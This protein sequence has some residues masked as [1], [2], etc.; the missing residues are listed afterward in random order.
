MNVIEA[1]HGRR[2][3]RTYRDEP[4]ERSLIEELVWAAV[5]APTPPASGDMPWAV[6]VIEGRDRLATL[7]ARAKSH[8]RET[9]PEPHARPWAERPD[10]QVFWG[11]PVAV[12]ICSRAGNPETPF[13]CCRAGQNLT[14]LAHARGLGSCWIGS[15]LPWLQ[16]DEGRLATGLPAGFDASSVVALGYAEQVLPGQSAPRPAITWCEAP[17]LRPA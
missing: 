6:A 10:F 3:I 7:G 13:D 12:L 11:A 16:S 9:Q 15:V 1:I 5:Q 14:L 8:A 17:A 2:S 4:V